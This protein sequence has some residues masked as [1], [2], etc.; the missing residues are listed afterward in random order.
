MGVFVLLL[1]IWQYD[2]IGRIG[3]I[4]VFVMVLLLS[5]FSILALFFFLDKYDQPN[6]DGAVGS[7]LLILRRIQK[8][9]R[10]LKM[11]IESSNTRNDHW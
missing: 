11:H 5:G 1:P 7:I 4:K 10:H 9:L 8:M 3:S 6:L 2:C